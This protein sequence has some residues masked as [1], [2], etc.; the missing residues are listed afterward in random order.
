MVKD[1]N[2]D[3]VRQKVDANSI[4]R[5]AHYMN[6]L[7]NKFCEPTGAMYK[8]TCYSMQMK[9]GK[10]NKAMLLSPTCLFLQ[11]NIFSIKYFFRYITI[12][13]IAEFSNASGD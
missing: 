12:E 11:L 13:E 6:S 3:F 1:G 10:I 5:G 2:G 4:F 7:K 8:V 9:Y